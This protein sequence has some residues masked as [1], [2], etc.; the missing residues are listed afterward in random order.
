M[1]SQLFCTATLLPFLVLS[2][3]GPS[4]K[5]YQVELSSHFKNRVDIGGQIKPASWSS[6]RDPE[7][8]ELIGQVRR[9]NKDL[10]A[11]SAQAREFLA[12]IRLAKSSSAV[13]IDGGLSAQGDFQN[14]DLTREFAGGLSGAF[15]VDLWG[16]FRKETKAAASR[17]WAS[18]AALGNLQLN[19]EAQ[20]VSA[21]YT[22]Q[23]FDSQIQSTTRTIETLSK[24]AGFVDKQIES[25]LLGSFERSRI[26]FAISTLEAER[27]ALRNDRNRLENALAVLVGTTPSAYNVREKS[28][29]RTPPSI[30]TYLPSTLLERRP[31]ILEAQALLEANESDIGVAW[32]DFFPRLNLLGLIGVNSPALDSIFQS[33]E[34]GSIGGELLGPIIDGG[35]RRANYDAARARRDKAL[36]EVESTV[37]SAFEDTENALSDAKLIKSEYLARKRAV[38][39]MRQTAERVR[40]RQRQGIDSLFQLVSV[41][42]RLNEEEVLMY[43]ARGQQ[44]VAAADV[45]RALGGDWKR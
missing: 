19:L 21:Y 45:V 36:A 26:D 34:A 35:K 15:E 43:A 8:L 7:V 17:A 2:C 31:D 23:S 12:L 3:S 5:D 37:L 38:D 22:L 27:V 6:F 28:L 20:A 11:A 44:F 10:K 39:N 18:T 25:G 41:E 32:A 40:E 33:N 24:Q 29:S 13:K 14:R 9:S 1:R 30:G 42:L 4:S 16:R